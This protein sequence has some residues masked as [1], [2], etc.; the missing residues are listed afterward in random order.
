[1]LRRAAAFLIVC[2]AVA[3]LLYGAAL[4]W[5]TFTSHPFTIGGL[6]PLPFP[7]IQPP[8]GGPGSGS[9]PALPGQGPPGAPTPVAATQQ[10]QPSSK[11]CPGLTLTSFKLTT[12]AARQESVTWSSSGG[13]APYGGLISWSGQGIQSGQAPVTT[14][15]GTTVVTISAP[16]CPPPPNN[17]TAAANVTFKIDLGDAAGHRAQSSV[18]AVVAL[19]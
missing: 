10:P 11:S 2:V 6:P 5:A 8:G 13:C 16:P 4:A 17:N 1:M 7:S 12:K 19:C 3:A 9:P 14:P 15:S 18:V